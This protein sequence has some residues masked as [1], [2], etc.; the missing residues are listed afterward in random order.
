[1]RL[2]TMSAAVMASPRRISLR[3]KASTVERERK[4]CWGLRRL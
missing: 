3:K 2:T 1:M 4:G